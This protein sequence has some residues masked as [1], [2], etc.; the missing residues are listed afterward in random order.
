MAAVEFPGEAPGSGI[1][2]GAWFWALG[3][4]RFPRGLPSAHCAM[5]A[6]SEDQRSSVGSRDFGDRIAFASGSRRS[7]SRLKTACAL[8]YGGHLRKSVKCS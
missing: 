4:P 7:A 3:R 6:I 1:G 2:N 8:P 5:A